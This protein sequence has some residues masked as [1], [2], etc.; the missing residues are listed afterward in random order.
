[1]ANINFMVPVKAGSPFERSNK[2]LDLIFGH[3]DHCDLNDQLSVFN[4]IGNNCGKIY[5]PLNVSLE[6]LVA[7]QHT[8][9]FSV[10][11]EVRQNKIVL[12]Y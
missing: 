10:Q 3:G 7:A 8:L 6:P 5:L 12:H 2:I 11:A 9:G 4:S 1:M